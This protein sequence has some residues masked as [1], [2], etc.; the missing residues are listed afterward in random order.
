[1]KTGIQF[2]PSKCCN[3]KIYYK[4]GDTGSARERMLQ[5]WKAARNRLPEVPRDQIIRIQ[6]GRLERP[7]GDG[8]QLPSAI[9]KIRLENISKT[10]L[11]SFSLI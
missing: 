10:E 2:D 11:L 8:T 7:R 9:R 3:A 4:L 1:M 5:I 6:L